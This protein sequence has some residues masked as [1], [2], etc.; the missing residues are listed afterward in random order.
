MERAQPPLDKNH[1]S[2]FHFTDG[3]E[4]VARNLKELIN[5]IAKDSAPKKQKTAKPRS[6][7]WTEDIEKQNTLKQKARK[8]LRDNPTI[9]NLAELKSIS[10]QFKSATIKAHR[11]HF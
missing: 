5:K 2:S 9:E 4:Q 8:S 7:W 1:P 6:S 10:K 11:A 3:I